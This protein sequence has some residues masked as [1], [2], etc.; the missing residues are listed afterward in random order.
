LGNGQGG[1]RFRGTQEK[2]FFCKGRGTHFRR[3]PGFFHDRTFRI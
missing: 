3:E 2:I 1:L